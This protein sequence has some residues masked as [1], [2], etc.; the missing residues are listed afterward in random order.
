MRVLITGVVQPFSPSTRCSRMHVVQLAELA[1]VLTHHGPAILYRHAAVPPEAINGYWTASRLRIDLWNQSLARFTRAKASGNHY[2]MRC[3][4]QDHT[5]VL[6]EVLASEVLTR[7]V[8]A[9]ADGIDRAGNRDEFSP[10]AQAIHL[11]HLEVRNRVQ[12]AILDRR[13]CAVQDAVRLNKLRVVVERWIDALIGHLS[14]ADPSLVRYG[15]DSS[16][17]RAHAEEAGTMSTAPGRETIAWLTQASMTDGLRR[18]IA[19]TP[20]LPHANREVAN[21]AMMILRPDLFDSVGV[22]KSLW[23]HRIQNDSDRTDQ[24]IQ[25]YLRPDVDDSATVSAFD[26]I[27]ASALAQ[28]FRY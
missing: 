20:S 21:S 17:T 23:V 8:A 6:E 18:I 28:W 4:W 22:L 16:R 2:R 11:S 12:E 7:V 9:L 27:H 10:I 1:A 15:I 24:M 13:G 26:A 14:G 5:G 25:D 19:K 3:W